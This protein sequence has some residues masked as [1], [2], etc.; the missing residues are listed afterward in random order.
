VKL[1]FGHVLDLLD[2]DVDFV[3]LPSIL[4][5]ESGAPGQKHSHYCPLIPASGQMVTA[6]VD[7]GSA[8]ARAVL[9]PLH[10][11]E[12][13]ARGRELP[14]AAEQLGVRTAQAMAA[15]E[16]GDA[17]QAAFEAALLRRGREVLDG[18]PTDR[19]AT[20]LIG[21]SY[22]TC[23]SGACHDLPRKLRRMGVLPIPLDFLGGRQ[24]DISDVHHDMFWYSGQAILGAARIIAADP[25]LQAIYVTNFHCGPD[26][27]LVSYFRRMMGAKPFL[28][29]EIDDHTAEAGIVTRCE[30]FFDS[31]RLLAP[32]AA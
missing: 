5:R 16:R 17:A 3:F 12:P 31:L 11:S 20:V 18:L 7:V 25:R 29:L 23:D 22:N 24:V 19:T 30:A 6:H 15:A 2:R 26:A 32:E 27:F 4:D 13:Q 28:E 8:G 14:V 21:R 9:F 1:V 10:M